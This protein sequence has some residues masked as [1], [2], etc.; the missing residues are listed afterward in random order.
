M[1]A[2]SGTEKALLKRL[3]D[4]AGGIEGLTESAAEL[5]LNDE[6]CIYGYGYLRISNPAL[7]DPESL[8]TQEKIIRG[9]AKS[10]NVLIIGIYKDV[11][12]S[13]AL[14]VDERPG[15]RDML[16]NLQP[17]QCIVGAA[18][19]RLFRSDPTELKKVK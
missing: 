9:Y 16:W 13:G 15:F 1:S 18:S 19:D 10:M 17:G 8:K 14:P 12:F 2:L 7:E 11:G 5:D 6:K 4:K 3:L